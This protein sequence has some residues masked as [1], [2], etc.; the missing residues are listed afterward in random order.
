MAR[1]R[2]RLPSDP[3]QVLGDELLE[4]FLSFHVLLLIQDCADLANHL[5]VVKALGVPGSQREA[6]EMLARA[7]M[8]ERTLAAEMAAASS[9]RNRIAHTYAEVDPVRLVEEAP[10]GL[11]VIERFLQQLAPVVAKLSDDPTP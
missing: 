7:Q 8:L 10:R 1:I 6:F 2:A 5:V 9:L 11:E 4:A 3:K